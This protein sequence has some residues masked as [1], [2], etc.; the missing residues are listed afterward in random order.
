MAGSAKT[1]AVHLAAG[2]L[3][4]PRRLRERLGA[5]STDVAGWLTGHC[6]P[7]REVFLRVVEIILDDLDAGGP[8][9]RRS[10]HEREQE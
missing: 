3:G 2:I 9:L 10:K 7:P 4:G 5:A 6:E 1:K 8:H